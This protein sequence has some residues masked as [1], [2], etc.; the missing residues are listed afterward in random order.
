MAGVGWLVAAGF[1]RAEL[2]TLAS[3]PAAQR[4]YATRGWSPT[5]TVTHV[6][7][8]SVAFDEVRFSLP[9]PTERP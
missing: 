7:L 1:G 5:G 3:N 4:F 2:S 6:D 8:G 9:G